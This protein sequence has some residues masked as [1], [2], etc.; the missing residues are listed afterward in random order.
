MKGLQNKCLPSKY[1][2]VR[3]CPI[4]KSVPLL[5]SVWS[6]LCRKRFPHA[7]WPRC[8]IH[9]RL[10]R[11]LPVSVA[12]SAAKNITHQAKAFCFVSCLSKYWSKLFS[13][14]WSEI[15]SFFLSASSCLFVGQN[16]FQVFD[17]RHF[18]LSLLLSASPSVFLL[19]KTILPSLLSLI[20]ISEPTRPP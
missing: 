15:F 3:Y 10:L 4:K 11:C 5:A 16:Y 9:C 12:T 20:H 1:T 17:W 7:H 13:S 19:V 14:F 18:F 2:C 6:D 8:P